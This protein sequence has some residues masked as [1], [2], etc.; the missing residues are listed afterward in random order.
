MNRH[1]ELAIKALLN[2]KG[3]ET[4]RAEYHFSLCTEKEMNESYTFDGKTRKQ[5]LEIF[6]ERDREYLEAIEWVKK[7]R[8]AEYWEDDVWPMK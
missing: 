4:E 1:Q 3:D 2:L 6:R 5:L 7:A 8:G